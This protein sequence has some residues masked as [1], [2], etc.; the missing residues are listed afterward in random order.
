MQRRLG[1][2]QHL[3]RFAERVADAFQQIRNFFDRR[4]ALRRVLERRVEV[5]RL[6]QQLGDLIVQ[7]RDQVFHNRCSSLL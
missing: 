5:L 2:I 3:E 7:C 4:L 1:I 6:L